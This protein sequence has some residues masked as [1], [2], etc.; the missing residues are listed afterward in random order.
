V[1]GQEGAPPRNRGG[2]RVP[3]APPPVAL[4]PHEAPDFWGGGAPPSLK[5]L[6]SSSRA[7][8]T[9]WCGPLAEIT[10]CAGPVESHRPRAL[11]VLSLSKLVKNFTYSR[12]SHSIRWREKYLRK[13][14][15]I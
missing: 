11:S 4:P 2:P 8:G 1:R 13:T 15:K 7:L 9:A 14:K 5:T 12:A 6:S 3:P 10:C